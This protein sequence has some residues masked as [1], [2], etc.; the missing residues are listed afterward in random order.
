MRGS[1]GANAK[2]MGITSGGIW[3]ERTPSV[4]PRKKEVQMRLH[5]ETRVMPGVS[6]AKSSAWLAVPADR[7]ARVDY[8]MGRN[9]AGPRPHVAM[10]DANGNLSGSD[11]I[12]L[13]RLWRAMP[14]FLV[15]QRHQH[16]DGQEQRQQS[17]RR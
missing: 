2:G 12:R 13:A 1:P 3:P 10:L 11:A 16:A 8:A 14:R 9:T 7:P 15:H 5:Q 4:P 6:S 17:D